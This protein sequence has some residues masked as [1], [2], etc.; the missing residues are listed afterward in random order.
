LS[1]D[2]EQEIQGKALLRHKP[3][4]RGERVEGAR[5]DDPYY[6]AFFDRKVEGVLLTTAAG[7]ICDA[8]DVAC[9]L[10]RRTR[11]ELIGDKVESIF[12]PSDSRLPTAREHQR[13]RGFFRGQ[14][15]VRR[16]AD[17]RREPFDASVALASYRTKVGE[18]RVLIVLRDPAEQRR[19]AELRRGTEE[20]FYSLARYAS[21]VIQLRN[22]DGSLRFT[23]PSIERAWGYTPEEV[24]GAVE[25][26]LVHPDDVERVRAEYAKIW[27][28]PGIGPPVEYRIRHKDGHWIHLEATANNLREDPEVEGMLIIHRDITERVRKEEELRRLKQDLEMRVRQRTAQLMTALEEAKDSEGMLRESL[29]MFHTTFE[30]AALGIAHIDLEG[31]WIRVNE[32]LSEV[33]GYSREELRKKTFDDVTHPDDLKVNRDHMKRLLSGEIDHYSIDMRCVRKDGSHLWINL[34]V[35]LLR[36]PSGKSPYF[37]AFVK[38]IDQHKRAEMIL[39][40]F[41]PREI[42]VL[43]LLTHGFTNR[44]IASELYISANTAKFHV[45]HVIEKLGVTDRT[46]AAYRAAELGLVPDSTEQQK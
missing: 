24:M 42:Q 29:K 46:E 12:D 40:S 15:R 2:Q 20:W 28:R 16:R 41:T 19:A 7:E 9:R 5:D 11:E 43:K 35:F 37:M 8:S 10:L 18:D 6:E 13:S 4:H 31:Y 26:E 38:D 23:S 44:Q 14:L 45:Q 21:D 36:H 33:L 27:A 39:R 3:P 25:L 34:S 22:T 30:Q 17:G 32:K 1:E